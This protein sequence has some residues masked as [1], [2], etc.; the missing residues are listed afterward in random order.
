MGTDRIVLQDETD[1]VIWLTLTYENAF[2]KLHWCGYTS[3]PCNFSDVSFQAAQFMD[4]GEAT[5][6]NSFTYNQG[7]A[8]S[9]FF[10][11]Y[12][13]LEVK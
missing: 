10:P 7:S 2:A 9:F 13:L 8:L 12:D 11:P 3:R 6:P 4:H 1:V 5:D